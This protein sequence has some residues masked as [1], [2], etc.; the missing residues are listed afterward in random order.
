MFLNVPK[1][2]MKMTIMSV[3]DVINKN[4]FLV[5][6]NKSV[7]SVFLD[8]TYRVRETLLDVFRHVLKVNMEIINLENVNL[9]VINVTNVMLM[10]TALTVKMGLNYLLIT[11][12]LLKIFLVKMTNMNSTVFVKNVEII[13]QNVL[14]LLTLLTIN[15]KNVPMDT[16]SILMDLVNYLLKITLGI[17]PTKM[18]ADLL[19]VI[20]N[21]Q[22]VFQNIN[23]YHVM[24]TILF[25]KGNVIEIV[26][27]VTT[28]T[29]T[30]V[31][32][33]T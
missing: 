29:L 31:K 14:L 16:L 19:N 24:E 12:V 17:T 13:V 25:S 33:V 21:V 6:V 10:V 28:K 32:P 15:V 5:K 4:V 1:K 8:A 3:L 30:P 27:L 9:V 2:L 18:L 20:L 7:I 23:V 26:L 22:V 11:N